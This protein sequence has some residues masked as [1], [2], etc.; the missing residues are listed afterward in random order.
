MI[1]DANPSEAASAD[2]LARQA[3][4]YSGSLLAAAMQMTHNTADA[5]DLV[6]ETFLRA[7]RSCGSFRGVHMRAWLR[8]ILSNAFIDLYQARR[9]RQEFLG[10]DLLDVTR[11]AGQERASGMERDP[12]QLVVDSMLDENL[13][14]AVLSLA[15]HQREVVVLADVEGYSYKEIALR[16]GVPI[17]TVMSRLHRGRQ[18]LRSAR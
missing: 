3:M 10:L 5:E 18:A 16:T 14:L 12:A 4:S 2:D 13:R 17:G 6:Q 8:R 9:R 1:T 11:Q 7:H 15:P